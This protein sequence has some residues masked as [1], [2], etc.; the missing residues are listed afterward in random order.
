MAR[1]WHYTK[2]SLSNALLLFIYFLACALCDCSFLFVVFV[3]FLFCFVFMLSSELCTI[4][5][6]DVPLIFF[7][8]AGHVPNWQ[9]RILLG[10]VEARSVYVF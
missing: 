9:P 4:N 8:P 1:G 3:L 6:V 2:L 5:T 10:M 7:C